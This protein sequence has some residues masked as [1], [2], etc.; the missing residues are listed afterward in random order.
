M[1]RS[2]FSL[3]VSCLLSDRRVTLESRG[4]LRAS[5]GVSSPEGSHRP[6][7]CVLASHFALTFPTLP[8]VSEESPSQRTL[9]SGEEPMTCG[10][11]LDHKSIT[12]QT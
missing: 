7:T 6:Q 10:R 8:L 11:D 3:L 12:D 2:L 4:G 9:G 1:T 5:G